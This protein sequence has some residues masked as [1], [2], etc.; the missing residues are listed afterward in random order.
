MALF[1]ISKGLAANLPTTYNEGYCYFTTDDGKF[2]IDVNS[3]TRTALNA[4]AADKLVS[5]RTITLNG[6]VSGSVNFDGSKNVTMTTTVANNSHNHDKLTPEYKEVTSD[7]MLDEFLLTFITDSSNLANGDVK[8]LR[9]YIHYEQGSL[10]SNIYFMTIHKSSSNYG[11]ITAYG[12]DS[13][14]GPRFYLRMWG[15]DSTL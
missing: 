15:S 3:T 8:D 10:P 11:V 12:Y 9:I 14:S 2:Y 13:A 7:S 5:A 1:K 6:D 4:V